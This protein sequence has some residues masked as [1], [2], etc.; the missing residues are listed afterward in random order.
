MIYDAIKECRAKLPRSFPVH[1]I[2]VFS[3][4]TVEAAESC[5]HVRNLLE[6]V[7]LPV[8]EQITDVGLQYNYFERCT[9]C[10]TR[11]SSDNLSHH[12]DSHREFEQRQRAQTLYMAQQYL[13]SD[14][15]DSTQPSLRINVLCGDGRMFTAF[16]QTLILKNYIIPPIPRYS[17]NPALGHNAL[18]HGNFF[19]FET[20]GADTIK[21][22]ETHTLAG[23]RI[24]SDRFKVATD[25]PLSLPH[26]SY[27]DWLQ[28]PQGPCLLS[29]F[30]HNKKALA[31]TMVAQMGYAKAQIEVVLYE[32][33]NPYLA[34]KHKIRFTALVSR[35]IGI[36]SSG[37]FIHAC[38]LHLTNIRSSVECTARN[39]SVA[40]CN[41]HGVVAEAAAQEELADDGFWREESLENENKS[42]WFA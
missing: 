2:G 34:G 11:N 8:A 32:E 25:I 28:N 7:D 41:E 6:Q 14:R 16:R 38:R 35:S 37:M 21:T 42:R 18:K 4:G 27:K 31:A 22:F 17:S 5:A 12:S 33:W 1:P 39:A 36:L 40:A 20:V 15:N 9:T 19:L 13:S 23:A 3:E 26:L 10:S 29:Y 30:L 24:I